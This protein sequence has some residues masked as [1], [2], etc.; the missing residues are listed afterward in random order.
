MY[1]SASPLQQSLAH[2]GFGKN[3]IDDARRRSAEDFESARFRATLFGLF[4]RIIGRQSELLDLNEVER[5]CKPAVRH[6]AGIQTVRIADIKGSEGRTHDFDIQF[7]PRQDHNKERWVNVAL[8]RQ[9]GAA[10]PPVELVKFGDVYFVRDGHH[11]ISVAKRFGQ[12]E[13][14]AEV[15]VYEEV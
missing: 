14:E 5:V 15:T 13:I 10:L 1:L 3:A 4:S 12:R 2:N 6:Y 9:N 8:A 7:N 11:R